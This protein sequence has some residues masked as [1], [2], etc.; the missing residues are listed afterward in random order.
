[1]SDRN[2]ADD[3]AHVEAQIHV[4]EALAAALEHRREVYELLEAADDTATASRDLQTLLGT[5][6]VGAQA[7]IDLQL[8]RLTVTERA[9]IAEHL[10]ELK[11]YVSTLG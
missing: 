10:R 9:R 8:R 6:E 5:D 2:T 3:R 1:M 11:D 7:V 4:Y